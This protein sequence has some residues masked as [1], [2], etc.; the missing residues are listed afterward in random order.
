MATRAK[1]MNKSEQIQFQTEEREEWEARA[2]GLKK[3][4]DNFIGRN[5]LKAH[6][7]INTF[8]SYLKRKY[9][10][11][12]MECRL[13]YVLTGAV[14]EAP[15]CSRYDFDGDDSI[16]HFIATYGSRTQAA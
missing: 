7:V 14:G 5:P 6:E 3:E 16:E 1:N 10:A 13:F 12:V 11:H 8:G 9:G 2:Q 4:W 15:M